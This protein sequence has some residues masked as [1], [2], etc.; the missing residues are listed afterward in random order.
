M[1]LQKKSQENNME[2]LWNYEMKNKTMTKFC[3]QFS[4]LI[5]FSSKKET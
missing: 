5:L 4:A 2:K 3:I 1:R